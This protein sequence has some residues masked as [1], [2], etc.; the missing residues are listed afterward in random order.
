MRVT[1]I[2][3][4]AGRSTRFGDTDKLAAELDGRP[5]LL[6]AVEAFA[7]RPEVHQLIVAGPPDDLD[8]FRS[9]FGDAL[10]FLGA[11][12]VAG[13]RAE[14]WET[15]RAALESVGTDATHIAVHDAA[16]PMPDS[17]MLDRVFEAAQHVDAVVPGVPVTDTLK[18][19]DVAAASTTPRDEDDVLADA[20][21]GNDPAASTPLHPVIETMDRSGVHRIQ[22]PQVFAADLLRRAYAEEAMPAGVTD[23]AAAV[24]RLG[25]PV[26]VVEGDPWNVKVTTPEDLTLVRALWSERSAH[27]PT[28]LF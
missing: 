19:V 5:L 24:E 2:F 13:G 3:P 4:A 9:R 28:S 16:R 15:V 27:A 7:R 8:R 26:H 1:T 17:G 21:L 10:S 18:R 25:S 6:R 12:I 22:T 14:R 11:T 23:D 20:I